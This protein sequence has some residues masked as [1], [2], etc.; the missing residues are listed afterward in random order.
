[1][2]YVFSGYWRAQYEMEANRK[3]LKAYTDHGFIREE[4][5][6]MLLAK[7]RRAYFPKY[8]FGRAPTIEVMRAVLLQE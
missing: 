1:M 2:R 3:N 5:I 6:Q 7:V 8:W 4:V